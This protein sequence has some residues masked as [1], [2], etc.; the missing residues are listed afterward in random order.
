MAAFREQKS[1]QLEKIGREIWAASQ[2]SG[3]ATQSHF[4]RPDLASREVEGQILAALYEQVG[5]TFLDLS[6]PKLGLQK[7]VEIPIYDADQNG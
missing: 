6:G 4:W 1:P 5:L 7:V 3:L 2:C